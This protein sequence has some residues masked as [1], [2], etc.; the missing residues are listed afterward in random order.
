MGGSAPT[1]WAGRFS[2]GTTSRA[3]SRTARVVIGAAGHAAATG[4]HASTGAT[5]VSAT[6]LLLQLVVA[7]GVVVAVIK[8]ASWLLQGRSRRAGATL[9]RRQPQLAVLA[10]QTL[11]KGVHVAV[12]RA[13]DDA[14]LLG[15]TPQRVTRLGRLDPDLLPAAEPA[16]SRLQLVSGGRGPASTEPSGTHPGPTWRSAIDQIR[17]RTVR[18]A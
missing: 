3:V 1:W 15:I 4:S 6:S 14:L 7:L 2:V 12:I 9:G 11:G 8:G 13:G 18:R 16:R 17:E 10:R 5:T